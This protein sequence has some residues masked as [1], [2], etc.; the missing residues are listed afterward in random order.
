MKFEERRVRR[1]LA[2]NTLLFF[3]AFAVLFSL[4]GVLVF[5]LVSA[6]VYR[7]ADAQLGEVRDVAT[8]VAVD[9]AADGIGSEPA[10][11]ATAEIRED[12]ELVPQ[13]SEGEG[14]GGADVSA[15]SIIITSEAYVASNPQLIY[16]WRDADGKPL[17]T[18]GLYSVYPSYFNDVPFDQGNIGRVYEARAGGHAYR[19]VNYAVDDSDG[20]GYLQVLVNVDSELALLDHFTKMLVIYLVAAVLGA[21]AASYFLSRKTIKPIVAS[22]N[23][24]TEFVQNAS[25]EL[26]TPLAIIR[27]AQERLLADPNARVVDKFEDVNAVADETKRL[28]RLVDDLMTLSSVDAPVHDDREME[29]VDV[30]G[31]VAEVGDLYADVAE[32]GGKAL[33]VV[34]QPAGE[35]LIDA[36]ALRQVA[37]ILLDNALKY[38]E[39]GDAVEL[40]CEERGGRVAVSVADTGRGIDPADRE[41]VFERFYRA[42]AAR[43]TPGSGLGLSIARALVER[44]RGTIAVEGNEPRGTRVTVMLPK[45]RAR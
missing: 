44:A 19:C 45:A 33:T 26:R 39:E 22:M 8:A 10:S 5:Q 38:T 42:D 29:P 12:I 9:P 31:V 30:S 34:A 28:A 32:V 4:F 20:S 43:T 40:R 36:D 14:D 24:Q 25:H 37:G 2:R 21:A 23:R 41:H 17:D 35:A 7:T 18:E 16:L 1:I 6:N 15:E 27:A 3:A 11:G 13:R